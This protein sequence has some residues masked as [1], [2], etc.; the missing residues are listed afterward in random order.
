MYGFAGRS[1][2][3]IGEVG[4][5]YNIISTQTLQVSASFCPSVLDR[6]TSE[7]HTKS[8]QRRF[9]GMAC[10]SVLAVLLARSRQSG[11]LIMQHG[12]MHGAVT[13]WN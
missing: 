8:R 3:F 7:C 2:N 9:F 1:F 11:R 10:Q 13:V 6:E 12:R 4:K 5:I